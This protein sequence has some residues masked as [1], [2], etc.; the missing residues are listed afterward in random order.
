MSSIKSKKLSRFVT[1]WISNLAKRHCTIVPYPRV[2]H[3]QLVQQAV[4]RRRPFN[5]QGS[6]FRDALIWHTVLELVNKHNRKVVLLTDDKDFRDKK[7]RLHPDLRKDLTDLR[8]EEDQVILIPSLSSFLD[9]YVRPGLPKIFESHPAEVLDHLGIGIADTVT[10]KANETFSGQI[11]QAEELHLPWQYEDIHLSSI[12]DCS[13]LEIS[14]VRK[15][16]NDRY[17]LRGHASFECEFDAYMFKA[18]VYTLDDVDVYE[19]DWNK[20]YA[21][22]ATTETLRCDFELIVDS[23]TSGKVELEI[24]SM[25]LEGFEDLPEW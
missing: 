20:H 4:T 25:S 2:S 15:V 11:M 3:S 23:P 22:V 13:D 1:G 6:G 10:T 18:D 8:K 5:S 24:L 9:K 19:F 16:P 12:V 21:W 7:G 14:D 17:L